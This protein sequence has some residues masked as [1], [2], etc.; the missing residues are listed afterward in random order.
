MLDLSTPSASSCACLRGHKAA[1]LCE[2]DLDSKTQGLLH[3]NPLVS[4][5]IGVLI[6]NLIWYVLAA[7]FSS[8]CQ[9][10]ATSSGH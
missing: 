3:L 10:I 4:D 5:L 7:S 9:K 2:S 1:H 6:P 8:E